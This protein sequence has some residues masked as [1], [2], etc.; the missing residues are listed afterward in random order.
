M[1]CDMEDYYKISEL[2]ERGWTDGLIQAHLGKPD[3]LSPNPVYKSQP[4]MRLYSQSRVSEVECDPE[5][6]A[7]LAKSLASKEKRSAS[8]QKAVETKKKAAIEWVESQFIKIPQI[9]YKKLINKACDSYNFHQIERGRDDFR[10]ARLDSDASFL[11]RITYN[12]IRHERTNYE[13][14]LEQ[15][16]G[17]TGTKEAYQALRVKI[18][19][20]IAQ[21][22]PELKDY[23]ESIVYNWDVEDPMDL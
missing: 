4:P 23:V 16:F 7:K 13:Q 20:A 18:D 15:L 19:A 6:Q 8:A 9:P 10:S 5:L 3:K 22:Y 17:K 2:K 1:T 12:Y 21:A 11:C 14:M